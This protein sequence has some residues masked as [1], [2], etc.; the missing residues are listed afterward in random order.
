MCGGAVSPRGATARRHP[1][2]AL[3]DGVHPGAGH[4]LPRERPHAAGHGRLRVP[5]LSGQLVGEPR[6]PASAFD[7]DR[8]RRLREARRR[9][10]APRSTARRSRARRCRS[11]TT[12]SASSRR[13]RQGKRRLYTGTE[14]TT[15][16]PVDEADAGGAYYLGAPPRLL[17]ADRR[18]VLL[19]HAHD[20]RRSPTWQSGV[21]Y[22]DGTPKSSLPAVRTADRTTGGSIA[23]CD[24]LALHA[25]P[26]Q[27]PLPRAEGVHGRQAGHALPLHARLQMG[28]EGDAHHERRPV[29]ATVRGYARYGRTSVA[30]LDRSEAR[31]PAPAASADG[32]AGGQPGASREPPERRNGAP[33]V[34]QGAPTE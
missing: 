11:S 22:V 19:F 8:A 17:P 24:G 14:P 16:K 13:S 6:P 10:S 31:D 23:R 9:C 33:G 30:S 1:P 5:P 29:A 15:T 3:A 32:H 7:V 28:A 20:E 34:T 25:P 12:S 4:R 26:D 21:Y 27:R 18:G 2:D